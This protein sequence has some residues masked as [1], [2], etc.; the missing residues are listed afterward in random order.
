[1]P[2]D[3][4]QILTHFACLQS[5]SPTA[6][7]QLASAMT[8]QEKSAASPLLRQ[9]DEVGGVYLV[10]AGSI[11]VFYLHPNGQEGTLYFVDPGQACFLSVHSV[12][13]RQPYAAWKSASTISRAARTST[14]RTEI[15]FEPARR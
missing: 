5:L 6:N 14:C 4:A 1:M 8:H 13:E 7:A 10:L 3:L 12:V 9:G 15:V 11:R 2:S